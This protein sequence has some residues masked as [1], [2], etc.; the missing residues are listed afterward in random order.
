VHIDPSVE[1]SVRSCLESAITGDT[2][3]FASLITALRTRHQVEP[4]RELVTALARLA[5]A[6]VT[7]RPI[8]TDAQLDALVEDLI[9]D[10]ERWFAF[11]D[12]GGHAAVEVVVRGVLGPPTGEQAPL[13]AP[14]VVYT[15]LLLACSHL[16]V[17]GYTEDEKWTDY[18]DELEDTLEY[19]LG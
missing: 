3:T 17:L 18:L 1:D 16:L 5:L 4:A 10:D 12:V 8:P 9:A 19:G 11:A 2:D 13:P 14:P 6:D 7:G 15:I